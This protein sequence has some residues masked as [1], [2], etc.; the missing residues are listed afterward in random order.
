MT[1]ANTWNKI[2][3]SCYAP[4]YDSIGKIFSRSREISISQLKIKENDHVLFI[5]CGTGLDLEF[6]PDHCRIIATDI[7]PAMVE[8]TKRRNRKFRLNLETMVMDGQKLSFP[9]QY[10]DKIILHLILA[11]IPDPVACISEAERLLKHG[12][13]ITVFDKFLP[14]G[15]KIS[16]KRKLIN[17]IAVFLVTHINRR[18]EDIISHT[19]LKIISDTN[20]DFGGIFRI[21]LL[22]KK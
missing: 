1:I 11:V 16:W 22:Q 20:A 13:Q 5:G 3:Y 6:L 4:F 8:R 12:G 15:Q 10:F 18:F 19:H 21:L 2:R 17:P 9:D 7:T 14:A